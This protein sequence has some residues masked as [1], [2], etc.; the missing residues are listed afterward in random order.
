MLSLPSALLHDR[1]NL[2]QA[3]FQMWN[4]SWNGI[5]EYSFKI[6]VFVLLHWINKKA[7]NP[8]PSL[9]LMQLLQ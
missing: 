1:L 6:T 7:K 9:E 4:V 3:K 8:H 2:S 5:F